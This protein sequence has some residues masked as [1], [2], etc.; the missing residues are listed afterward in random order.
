MGDNDFKTGDAV[1]VFSTNVFGFTKFEWV[2]RPTHIPEPRTVRLY[3]IAV[4]D[5][6]GNPMPFIAHPRLFKDTLN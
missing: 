2:K 3:G 5:A 4:E 1:K 6:D